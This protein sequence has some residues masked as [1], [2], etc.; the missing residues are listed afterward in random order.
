[1]G[2][3]YIVNGGGNDE[4]FVVPNRLTE[5]AEAKFAKKRSVGGNVVGSASKGQGRTG[6]QG[7][8]GKMTQGSE[9]NLSEME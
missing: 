7:P 6:N 4:K 5:G 8:L 2:E 3:K 9:R 1:M